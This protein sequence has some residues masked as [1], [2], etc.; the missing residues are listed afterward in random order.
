MKC[1]ICQAEWTPPPNISLS[2]C[3]FCQADILSMVNEKAEIQSADVILNNML[4]IYGRELLQ[5]QQRLTAMI[6]DLFGHD[7]RTKNILLLSIKENIPQKISRLLDNDNQDIELRA[8]QNRLQ[9]D[10]FLHQDAAEQMIS[11][12]RFILK[13][14]VPDDSFEIVWQDGYCGFRS[15]NGEMI[16]PFKYDFAREFNCGLARVEINDKFGFVNKSGIEIIPIKYNN[17][18][19]FYDGLCRVEINDKF[20]FINERGI[21]IIPI[22][23]DFLYYFSEGLC[24]AKINGKYGYINKSGIVIIPFKYNLAF[25]FSE[26]FAVVSSNF[27]FHIINKDD[28]AVT[29][30][31]YRRSPCFKEGLALV[32][33]DT[34]YGFIAN[35]GQEITP[36]KYHKARDF[37]H[38]LAIVEINNKWGVINK[39]GYE[40]T[41][42]KYDHIYDFNEGMAFFKLNG[43]RGLINKNGLEIP[44]SQ[45]IDTS[46]R[47][48][49][50]LAWV[51]DKNNMFGYIDKDGFVVIPM[52]FNLAHDFSEGLSSIKT[53]GKFG[54]ID[55][56]GSQ[57]IPPLY[58]D[59]TNFQDGLAPVKMNDKWG[60]IDKI[61]K[62]V[63]PFKYDSIC[64]SRNKRV[65]RH[66]WIIKSQRGYGC[67]HDSGIEIIPPEYDFIQV[68]EGLIVATSE[69][70]K[71]IFDITG[72]RIKPY[73]KAL[74][75]NS[76]INDDGL[77][78]KLEKAFQKQLKK[79]ILNDGFVLLYDEKIQV[80][81]VSTIQATSTIK[82]IRED[83]LS[84]SE[85][86][87]WFSGYIDFTIRSRYNTIKEKRNA[88][89]TKHMNVKYSLVKKDFIFEDNIA[90]N[91]VDYL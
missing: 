89:S 87:F 50:G 52:I 26:G 19:H 34:K 62:L 5:N 71:V 46:Q 14:A 54:F 21:V 27:K 36:L 75:D 39:F 84:A 42:L 4:Q 86:L 15:S 31:I 69:K 49:E 85:N 3:P 2:K 79:Q 76:Y 20:G 32:I 9:E 29:Q 90:I 61:G 88:F 53:K 56:S 72:N 67:V 66:L 37:N 41:P 38:G 8:L 59:A 68:F 1:T 47:F 91:L 17:A 28:V 64:K 7:K 45:Y 30:E 35:N 25:P 11:Y 24:A 55:I 33:K 81:D 57:I 22:I 77:I 74:K 43:Q 65:S 23:Y 83:L 60:L 78:E 48:S 58:D 40:I 51:C 73:K 18:E 80:V 82:F 12:W 63:V 10:S 6:S 13:S 70:E 16:T 44:L